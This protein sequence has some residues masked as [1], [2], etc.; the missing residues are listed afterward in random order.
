MGLGQPRDDK[1]DPS[2]LAA[3]GQAVR[4]RLLA[5]PRAQPQGGHRA[6]LFTVPGFVSAQRCRELIALIERDAMPST[7]F[8]D[9]GGIAPGIRTSSTH[10]FRDNSLALTLG[11]EIDDL[12][13]LDG[14]HAEPM[15]G[16]RYR[17]GEEYRHHSDHF[18]VERDHWQRERLR[19][20][21]RTWTAMLYLNAVDA[22]GD[23]DFPR[24]NIRIRPEPG[25]LVAWNNMDRAG[26]PNSALLHAGCP[27]LEGS[28]YVITQWYR[29]E[30]WQATMAPGP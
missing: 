13:G 22:G 18:R 17:R 14:A 11:R 5:D 6:D 29:L 23:T 15:Q 10:Y 27:V 4:S 19:G 3:A 16:Q 30:Q 12:L 28:K 7:L 25:L 21:Q 1:A 8:H 26:K 20:G 24:L 9:G 2:R